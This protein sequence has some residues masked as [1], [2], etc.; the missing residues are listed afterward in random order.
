M[1]ILRVDEIRKMRK[2][3]QSK[4]LTELKAELSKLMSA[5]AMGGSMENPARIGLIKKTIAQFY[6]IQ[7]EEE[8]GI[9]KVETPKEK[10]PKMKERKEKEAEPTE[11]EAKPRATRRRAKKETV[12]EEEKEAKVAGE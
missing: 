8:L 10:K 12:D 9:R 1:A 6:T 4:K 3:E 11:K 5:R 7:R 2:E